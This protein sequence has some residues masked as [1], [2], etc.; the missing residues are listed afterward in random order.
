MRDERGAEWQYEIA[1]I[2]TCDD[3]PPG[4]TCIGEE[5]RLLVCW[6][7]GSETI[8]FRHIKVAL[9]V[10]LECPNAQRAFLSESWG[11]ARAPAATN[12]VREHEHLAVAAGGR[13]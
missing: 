7:P 3:V 5:F 11:I 1:G 13:R 9:S 4:G 6:Q 12:G 2:G 8:G 10:N